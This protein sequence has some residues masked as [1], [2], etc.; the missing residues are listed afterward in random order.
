MNIQLL[1]HIHQLFNLTSSANF[2]LITC[3]SPCIFV[4]THVYYCYICS[5]RQHL[6]HVYI[7]RILYISVYITHTFMDIQVDAWIYKG[8]YTERY[9]NTHK[10]KTTLTTKIKTK[11]HH[12][13]FTIHFI[14]YNSNTFQKEKEERISHLV[15]T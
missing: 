9:I 14:Y 4:Y 11:P 3:I 6:Q 8:I 5:N 12:I 13:I 1:I 15:Y 2:M 10:Y 7:S